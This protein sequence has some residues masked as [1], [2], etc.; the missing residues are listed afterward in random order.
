MHAGALGE[1]YRAD[2]GAIVARM[3]RVLGGDFDLAE[4]VVQEAFAAALVQWPDEGVPQHPKAWLL[5][6][7]R[8][9]AVDRIRRKTRFEAPLD[10]E[11]ADL[12]EAAQRDDEQGIGDVGGDD[13]LR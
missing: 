12:L 1:V 9:K 10:D 2:S 11:A 6:A 13:R 3:I 4:E 5:R 7:A 8:N